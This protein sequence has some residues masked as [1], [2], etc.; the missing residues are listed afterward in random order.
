MRP[1]GFRTIHCLPVAVAAGLGLIL[2]A[3]GC[4]GRTTQPKPAATAD[5]VPPV[6]TPVAQPPAPVATVVTPTVPAR[7][8]T[9]DRQ[10]P[11]TAHTSTASGSSSLIVGNSFVRRPGDY[12]WI[13]G[14]LPEIVLE[15]REGT[16]VTKI[17]SFGT[18]VVF[19]HLEPGSYS[20]LSA[21]R[22]CDGNCNRLDARVGE[23]ETVVQVPETSRLTVEHSVGRPC[24]VATS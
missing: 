14:A 19:D 15:S 23:C 20:V 13:E 24:A 8:A 10:V 7:T 9:P 3:A 22:P 2:A 21:A 1:T 11:T 16:R 5:V 18:D 4:D 6:P 12:L 17:G